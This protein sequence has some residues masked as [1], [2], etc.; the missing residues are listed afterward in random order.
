MGEYFQ[1]LLFESILELHTLCKL[2]ISKAVTNK[3]GLNFKKKNNSES[4]KSSW[5]YLYRIRENFIEGKGKLFEVSLE[6]KMR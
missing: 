6:V 4:T 5:L 1:I 3:K 2:C